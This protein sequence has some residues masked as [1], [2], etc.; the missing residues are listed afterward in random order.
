MTFSE[1]TFNQKKRQTMRVTLN[2][3]PWYGNSTV[4]IDFPL[5]WDVA[6]HPMAGEKDTP[7]SLGQ[8]D[9]S[10]QSPVGTSKLIDLAQGKKRAVIVFDDMTRPTR[11]YEIAPIVVRELLK[12]GLEEDQITFVCALGTHG[13]LSMVDFRKKLG[14]KIIERHRVYN[15]NIYENCVEIGTTRMCHR[16]CPGGIFRWRKTDTAGHIPYRQYFTLSS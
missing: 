1:T 10:L 9:E 6:V 13:A 3:K 15:H 12:A 11:I 16:T 8:I 7:L 4:D 2:E 14:S 5:D